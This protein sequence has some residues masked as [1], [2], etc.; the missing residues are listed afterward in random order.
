[1]TLSCRVIAYSG[2]EYITSVIPPSADLSPFIQIINFDFLWRNPLSLRTHVKEMICWLKKC[3]PPPEDL[4]ACWEDY[5]F[6]I[7]CDSIFQRSGGPITVQLSDAA[8]H[9][10]LSQSPE[11]LRILQ[12][13]WV[14]RTTFSGM[15]KLRM[16]SQFYIRFLLHIPWDDLRAIIRASRALLGHSS[17]EKLFILWNF[18]LRSTTICPEVYPWPSTC[19]DLARGCVRLQLDQDGLPSSQ[20][21][22]IEFWSQLVRLSPPCNDL[23]TDICNLST[24]LEM[25]DFDIH[26]VLEWLKTFPQ[27]PL[28]VIEH[29]QR[30]LEECRRA[31]HGS[32]FKE[33]EELWTDFREQ[34]A[35]WC[36]QELGLWDRRI[37]AYQPK[38]AVLSDS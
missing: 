26:N 10:I 23:L 36:Q 21:S 34:M 25:D 30:C 2:L 12:A 15:T 6:I 16:K 11:L 37:V 32:T 24:S 22:N 35:Y 33:C 3:L 5:R 8:C 13:C 38:L 9:A 7:N 14:C 27:P 18:S 29:W 19:R 28:D 1:M 17:R 20:R 31:F 4:I